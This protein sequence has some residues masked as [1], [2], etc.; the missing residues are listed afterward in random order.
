MKK[1]IEKIIDRFRNF[2]AFSSE[3]P[4]YFEG[5][6]Q[7]RY[8]FA[9]RWAG[10][11]NVLDVGCSL[12]CGAHHLAKKGA[13]EVLGV[14]YSRAAI[15]EAKKNYRLP[16]LDFRVADANDLKAPEKKFETILAFEILEHLAEGDEKIFFRGTS[17]VLAE[18]GLL[19]LSTPNKLVS[20]PRDAKPPNPYHVK[21]YFPQELLELLEKYFSE[22]TLLGIKCVNPEYLQK[23]KEL[24]RKSR[25][26]GALKFL[27]RSRIIRGIVAFIPMRMRQRITGEA[28][29]PQLSVL[30]FRL[31]EN[32]IEGAE[33]L[34]AVCKK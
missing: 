12:G 9:L 8:S 14:D 23:Q 20:S 26:Y 28:A 15:A 30:D 18:G 17:E 25:R 5:L 2:R 22:V 29:L 6:P 21:E 11:K 16:N 32:N 13:R 24:E 27:G 4:Q 19:L 7:A 3:R 31:I 10:G 34:F 33:S 1:R